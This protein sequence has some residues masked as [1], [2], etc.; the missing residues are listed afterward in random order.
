MDDKHHE[1]AHDGR[2]DSGD[3]VVQQGSQTHAT[4]GPGIQLRHPYQH[5]EM[6]TF[7]DSHCNVT[8]KNIADGLREY[9]GR[10]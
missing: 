8:E 10:K 7:T 4:R 9:G 1:D 2:H 6:R 3:D 5:K